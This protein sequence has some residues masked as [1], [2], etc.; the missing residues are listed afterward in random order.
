MLTNEYLNKVKQTAELIYSFEE[1][2]CALNNL[3]YQLD[4]DY[5]NKQPIFLCVV[6]GGI[7]VFSHLT[8]KL[9][10]N[11]EIDYIH[12][13]RYNG[14]VN[15]K[16]NLIWKK[17]PSIN[18]VNRDII[19]VDDI[20]DCGITMQA[21]IDYCQSQGA[22]SVKS[23]VLLDRVGNRNNLGLKAADYTALKSESTRYFFGFGMDFYSYLRNINAIYAVDPELLNDILKKKN[24][25]LID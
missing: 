18:I 8:C 11:I 17:K 23:L 19:I 10:L 2:D 3:A 25:A 16:N 7:S 22:K 21:L 24:K 14:D 5:Q 20:L 6:L 15:A 13:T 9:N 4:K 1:I 12:A